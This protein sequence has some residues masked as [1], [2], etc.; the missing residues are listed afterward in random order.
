MTVKPRSIAFHLGA[1]KTATSHLQRC[2]KKASEALAADGVQYHGPEKF[3]SETG[4]IPA[5]F[6]FR[7]GRSAGDDRPDPQAQLAALS[8]GADRLV[9]SEENFIGVLNSPRGLAI[10]RR[11]KAAGERL[12]AL[13]TAIGQDVDVFLGI[14]RPTGF[15]NS[16]YGQMLLGGQVRPLGIFL[17]RNPMSSV[18]WLDVVTRIRQARGVGQV[19]V[20]RYEDYAALFPQIVTGLVGAVPSRHVQWVERSVNPGLSAAAV[21]EILHRAAH[22]DVGNI[23]FMV[24]KMLP[25]QSGYPPFDGFTEEEHA[26]G[27]AAYATQVAAITALDGVTLLRPPAT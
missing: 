11:Y 24:R 5:L 10:R 9:L 1:H 6:G 27:D 26:R 16:A 8:Q 19:T 12:S 25:V 22:D 4:T 20:W 15:I 3:R 21:A 18:D 13:S 17:R 2:L 23:G 7:Q 14:R